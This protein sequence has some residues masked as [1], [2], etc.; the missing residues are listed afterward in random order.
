MVHRLTLALAVTLLAGCQPA[1][2]AP[3]GPITT[4]Q[5][6]PAGQVATKLIGLAE[7]AGKAFDGA[8][9]KVFRQGEEIAT[10]MTGADGRFGIGLSGVP[11]GVPLKV[12]ATKNGQTLATLAVAGPAPSAY[13]GV[14]QSGFADVRLT[15]AS[16]LAMLALGKRLEAALDAA[17]ARDGRVLDRPL[18]T[19]LAAFRQMEAAAESLTVGAAQSLQDAI[20]SGLNG[21]GQG[22]LAGDVAKQLTAAAPGLR[23]V[24][25]AAADQLGAAIKEAIALSK[26]PLPPNAED[27]ASF[28]E[29]E[30]RGVDTPQPGSASPDPQ[31]SPS[32][33]GSTV[34]DGG[35]D[36]DDDDDDE[37]DDDDDDPPAQTT[38]PKS[39]GPVTVTGNWELPTLPT[40]LL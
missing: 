37:D 9:V 32:T 33:P 38:D 34:N 18:A 20:L 24:F 36:H 6:V 40:Q 23:A 29:A 17:V 25:V 21:N 7:I 16:T 15:P 5:N 39:S 3:A 22:A 10:G 4:S 11:A 8:K 14:L 26:D 13:R 12:V 28:G 27:T 30:S 19:A 1:P 31:N 2:V 35:A